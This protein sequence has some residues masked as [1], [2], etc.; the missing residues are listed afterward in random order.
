MTY[1]LSCTLLLAA[2]PL[3][4]SAHTL[5]IGKPLPPVQVNQLGEIVLKQTNASFQTWSTEE[6]KGKVH[7]IQ[8]I[9]GRSGAK[10][11]NQPL[12]KAI[13]RAEFDPNQYQTTTIINQDDAIWGTGSFVKSSAISG[14]EEFPWSSVVLD[15]QG[16]VA[17]QWQLKPE[18]SAIIVQDKQGNVLFVKEGALSEHEIEVVIHLVST[19]L[20]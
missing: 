17:H 14:K 2:L 8:A 11:M 20:E 18:S 9:A 3:F 15:E 4:A 10:A 16:K 6:M 12:M 7:I 19:H 1:R 5:S 13:T